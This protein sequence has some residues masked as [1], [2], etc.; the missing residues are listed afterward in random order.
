MLKIHFNLIFLQVTVFVNMPNLL[1]NVKWVHE[2]M[3]VVEQGLIDERVEVRS[4]AS[5]VLGGLLHCV[6]VDKERQNTLL[7]SNLMKKS[8]KCAK[9]VITGGNFVILD[10]EGNSNT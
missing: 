3:D 9:I 2:V 6:F 10:I 8:L 7:V 5:E 4:K 1:S